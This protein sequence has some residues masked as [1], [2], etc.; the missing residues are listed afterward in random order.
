MRPEVHSANLFPTLNFLCY[1]SPMTSL[2]ARVLYF[3]LDF[4]G[5]WEAQV[6]S[7]CVQSPVAT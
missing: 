4:L 7:P 2:V 5:A 3:L 1:H 6:R